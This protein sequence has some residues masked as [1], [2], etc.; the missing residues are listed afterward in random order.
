L[1]EK[2]EKKWDQS[3]VTLAT[4]YLGGAWLLE[5]IGL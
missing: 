3:S 1:K 4:T 2:M 5:G